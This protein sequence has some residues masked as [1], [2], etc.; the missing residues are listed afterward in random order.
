M[1]IV[2]ALMLFFSMNFLGENTPNTMSLEKEKK[3]LVKI[4][5]E[6]GTT[7]SKSFAAKDYFEKEQSI[8][9]KYKGDCTVQFSNG[10]CKTTASNCAAAQAGFRAC[11]CELGHTKL[12]D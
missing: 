3:V 4:V 2:F 7:I 6:D 1:K 11:A 5:L 12:C 10:E 9:K 8:L